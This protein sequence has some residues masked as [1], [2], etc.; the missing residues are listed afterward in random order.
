M[1][2]SMGAGRRGACS[3]RICDASHQA[4]SGGDFF[5]QLDGSGQAADGVV[6]VLGFLETHGGVGAQF[7]AR[8]CFAHGGGLEI[9][10]LENQPARAGVDSGIAA[11]DDAGD[12]DGAALIGDDQVAGIEAIL[13]LV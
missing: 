1:G 13:F 7:L 12:G 6:R 11:A 9:G 2:R 5:E 10:A 4:D 3:T 8:G